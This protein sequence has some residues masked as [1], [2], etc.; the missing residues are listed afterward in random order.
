MKELAFGNPNRQ[1][2]LYLET[3][4]YL[5][6]LLNELASYPPPENES[7]KTTEE[8]AEL[9][10]LTD[11]LAKND[12]LLRRFMLYD[13]DFEGYLI[14]K[15]VD[16]GIPEKDVT[17]LVISIH[18][19]IVPL[20]VKIKFIYNRPR[21]YQL[22]YY[23]QLPLHVWRTKSTDSPS[24]PS[25]HTFQARI[26]AEVLGN[27]YPKYYKALQELGIDIMWSR[28]YLGAH[29]QSDND[30]ALYMADIVLK[31]P[32]FAKKYKL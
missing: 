11:E 28:K 24:Y 17:D 22:A 1:H 2:L 25:G 20:L 31:H 6:S 15:L 3:N 8:I 9:I 18:K 12:S 13:T 32:E 30:F 14:K 29:Y 26:L 23:K 16:S 19:D 5:D 21:P 10:P 4:T 7:V 27:T